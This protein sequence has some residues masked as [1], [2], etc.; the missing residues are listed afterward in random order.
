MY[1]FLVSIEKGNENYGA[2]SPDLTGCVAVEDA[3]EESKRT[4]EKQSQ[5]IYEG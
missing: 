2:Y 1:R 3:M 4:C 5:C